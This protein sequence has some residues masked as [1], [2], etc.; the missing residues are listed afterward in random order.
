[1][2]E[3]DNPQRTKN[4]VVHVYAELE[5]L[6]PG[7]L[8]R[9]HQ[10]VRSTL[11]ALQRRDYAAIRLLGHRIKGDGGAFGFDAIADMGHS[12]H[13][14][15]KEKNSA[16]IRKLVGGLSAYLERVEVVYE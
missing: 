11:E 9:K 6:I 13:Q 5:D 10:D 4:V 3:Y 16:A 1:M 12:L 8:D 2:K 14:A 15:A 7:F